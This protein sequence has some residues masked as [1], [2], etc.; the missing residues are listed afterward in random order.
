[1]KDSL[2]GNSSV[3][4]PLCINR[5]SGFTGISLNFNIKHLLVVH[6]ESFPAMRVGE[7]YLGFTHLE[8]FE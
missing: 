8:R 5:I 3:V 7:S 2:M 1:M 4:Y 6:R